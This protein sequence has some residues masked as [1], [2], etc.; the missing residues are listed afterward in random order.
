[1]IVNVDLR[2][3]YYVTTQVEVPDDTPPEMIRDIVNEAVITED[4][5]PA[6]LC[7]SCSGYTSADPHWDL[8]SSDE[9]EVTD[10]RPQVVETL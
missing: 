1:M 9:W 6:T 7:I 10:I 5:V 8:D 3:Y 2:R 4:V